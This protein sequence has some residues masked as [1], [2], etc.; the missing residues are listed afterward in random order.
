MSSLP[1]RRV[2]AGLTPSFGPAVRPEEM[3]VYGDYL[4]SSKHGDTWGIVPVQ[5]P[6]VST[7]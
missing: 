5:Q 3:E 2:G 6:M 4:S 7:D 1:E